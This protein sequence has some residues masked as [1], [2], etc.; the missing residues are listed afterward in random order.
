MK[1]THTAVP[2]RS[3]TDDE[4]PEDLARPASDPIST[5]SYVA[6]VIVGGALLLLC[7]GLLA[8]VALGLQW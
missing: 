2:V 5:A 4:L 1:K 8:Y 6:N 7:L 3:R